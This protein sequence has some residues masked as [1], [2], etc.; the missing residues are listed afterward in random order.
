MVGGCERVVPLGI[1]C[2][3]VVHPLY[4][5]CT[6][7]VHPLYTRMAF[8]PHRVPAPEPRRLSTALVWP[9]FKLHLQVFL[10]PK[11]LSGAKL[12]QHAV[13]QGQEVVG[14]GSPGQRL[15]FLDGVDRVAEPASFGIGSSQ[16]SQ[17]AGGAALAQPAGGFG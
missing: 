2:T 11:R 15:G 6:S 9:L 17:I 16:R 4:I 13:L 14:P 7:V 5:R 12:L 8:G 3:T 1:P 10:L